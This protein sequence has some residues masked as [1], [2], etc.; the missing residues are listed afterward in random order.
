[1]NF[2]SRS[3]HAAHSDEDPQDDVPKMDLVYRGEAALIATDEQLTG[4]I[5][6]LRA[7][8]NFAYDSEFIGELTYYP[9][10]CL[11]QVASHNTLALI[12]PLAGINM[13]PFWELLAD[14]VVTK[15]VHAGNSDLEPVVRH[16]GRPAANVFDTQIGAGFIGLPYPVSLKKLV[17]DLTG[18]NLGRDLG[19]SNW[20]Q[21][22]L[23]PSQL[24]YAADDVRYLLAVYKE[25]ITRLDALGRHRW[26]EEE[27]ASSCEIT[28]SDLNPKTQYLRV[29]GRNVLTPRD[30]AVLRELA[31]WRDAAA[32]HHN[33][34][35]RA[36]LKD[37]VMVELAR[38]CP[39]SIVE[40][41]KFRTLPKA[42]VEAFGT[43][44]VAAVTRGNAL[45]D[46]E[47]PKAE[48][49]LSAEDKFRADSLFAVLQCICAGTKL[50]HGFVTNRK[51]LEMFYQ[52]VAHG[53]G[54][55]PALLQGW[56][57]ECVGDLLRSFLEGRSGLEMAWEAGILRTSS[58]N[59]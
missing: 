41:A 46:T 59:H 45:P 7:S 16:L 53:T 43:D 31:A 5:E 27:C 8:G 47:L 33:K 55:L 36:L 51:E 17:F 57:R 29:R 22:P 1:M 37:E 19:L 28:S 3:H 9:K 4:L 11:V 32:R 54:D 58:A 42:I 14:P 2:R 24:R 13:M 38:D 26:A 48:S 56:R 50:D 52:H 20:Q 34:P 25:M 30:Q 35:P 15:I 21:R 23:S 44:I 18:A 39:R 10:L 40:L 6:K 12:D 49:E